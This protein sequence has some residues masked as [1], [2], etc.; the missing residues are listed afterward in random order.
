M[1]NRTDA[2]VP[3]PGW[4]VEVI[5]NQLGYRDSR[6]GWIREAA[7]QRIEREGLPATRAEAE[8]AGLLDEDPDAEGN[9]MGGMATGTN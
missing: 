7:L 8:A 1:E 2:T 6:A 3:L 9:G 4:M 5:E